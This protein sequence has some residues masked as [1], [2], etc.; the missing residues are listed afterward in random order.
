MVR[1]TGQDRVVGIHRDDL[2]VR[3]KAQPVARAAERDGRA[4]LLVI[5]LRIG[6]AGLD[7]FNQIPGARRM[8]Q[9]GQGGPLQLAY[10]LAGEMDALSHFRARARLPVDEPVA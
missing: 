3:D 10:A 8:A 9:P 4:G 7:E 2:H 5:G 6:M 1:A